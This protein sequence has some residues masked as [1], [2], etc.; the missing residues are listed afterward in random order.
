[1]P[2][3]FDPLLSVIER[4]A[5]D[6]SIDVVKLEALLRLQREIM[7]DNAK[8][9]FDAAYTRLTDKIP[10][11]EKNG[12]IDLGKG[13]PLPFARWEDINVIIQP[14]LRAEGFGL[15]FTSRHENGMIIVVGSLV[16]RFGHSISAEMGLPPDTGPGR[17][18]LQA[19]G[20]TLTYGKRYVTEMLLNIVRKG[21][22]NDGRSFSA[23]R[24]QFQPQQA[25]SSVSRP[26][27]LKIGGR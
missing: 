25:S 1:M 11:I 6:P 3:P 7:A 23:K 17:N 15:T 21:E 2:K 5:H 26:P 14:L 16:H 19:M 10:Q 27:P 13:A 24:P 22:D 12:R 9:E 4:A 20:S 18:A 8:A